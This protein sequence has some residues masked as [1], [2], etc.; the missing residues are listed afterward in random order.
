MNKLFGG[1]YDLKLSQQHEL[2][3][4]SR[5]ISSVNK[6]KLADVSGMVSDPI[7]RA[8]DVTASINRL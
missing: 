2:I 6:Q 7:I 3:K 4:S 5:A 8:S 1:I